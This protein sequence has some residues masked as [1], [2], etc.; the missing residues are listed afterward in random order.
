MTMLTVIGIPAV[1]CFWSV[2]FQGG[3]NHHHRY[4]MQIN[5]L[6]FVLVAVIVRK[7]AEQNLMLRILISAVL[8]V[9]MLASTASV[10]P[11]YLSFFN[12]LAGGPRN[13][14]KDL[15]FSNINWGQG[16]LFVADW[17]EKHP[18]ARPIAFELDY[19]NSKGEMFGLP[20]RSP[21]RH[22]SIAIEQDLKGSID[23]E[24]HSGPC[25]YIVNVRKLYNLPSSEGLQYLQQMNPVDCIAYSFNVYKINNEFSKTK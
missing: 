4:V 7:K 19:G 5:P 25:W 12:S 22:K 6:L 14:W 13:G 23:F 24:K 11:H 1:V 16:L 15:G 10:A 17:I 18:E 20:S 8:I 21:K 2:S 9:A 3:F